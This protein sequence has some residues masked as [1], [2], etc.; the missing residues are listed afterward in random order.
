[1]WTNGSRCPDENKNE[2]DS[3]LTFRRSCRKVFVARNE[4]R[5]GKYTSMPKTIEEVN[6]EIGIYPLPHMPVVKDLVPDLSKAYD[7]LASI[8]LG[9]KDQMK[10]TIQKKY[11]TKK[12]TNAKR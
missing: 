7:Q 1:M 6:G 2:I 8:K 5:W 11:I 10:T 3:S 9:C 4:H 12:K